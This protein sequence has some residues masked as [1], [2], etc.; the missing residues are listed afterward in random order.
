MSDALEGLIDELESVAGRLRTGDL[1]PDEAAALVERS[2][3]L[4][5][6]IGRELDAASRAADEPQGQERLL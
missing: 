5:G 1:E 2:A 4:A 3:D 6:R